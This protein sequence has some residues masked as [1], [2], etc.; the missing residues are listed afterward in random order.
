MG[1]INKK[2]DNINMHIID[3]FVF[4]IMGPISAASS[5]FIIFTFIKY[6]KMRERPGGFLILIKFFYIFNYFK[7]KNNTKDIF[8]GI[9]IS[10][11]ILSTH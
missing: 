5:T 1:I 3:A 2:L 6:K 8:L 4:V 11:L 7:T 10:E 9:S